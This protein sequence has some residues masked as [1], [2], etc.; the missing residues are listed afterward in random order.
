[1]HVRQNGKP[2]EEMDCFESL[3]GASGSRWKL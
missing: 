2:F 3:G 1:M